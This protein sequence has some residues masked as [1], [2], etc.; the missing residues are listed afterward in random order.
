MH[1]NLEAN[2]GKKI[3][4]D[5]INDENNFCHS[6]VTAVLAEDNIVVVAED[7]ADVAAVA[8]GRLPMGGPP[9]RDQH[10]ANPPVEQ[11]ALRRLEAAPVVGM[12]MASPLLDGIVNVREVVH[13]EE[14]TLTEALGF[15]REPRTPTMN[16]LATC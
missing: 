4:R 2:T 12:P 15:A 6:L 5:W 11:R 16:D 1:S 9:L 8:F 10:Y 14:G 13:Q 3:C 7:A